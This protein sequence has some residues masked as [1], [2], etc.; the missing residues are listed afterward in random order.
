MIS[1]NNKDR[2]N[3]LQNELEDLKQ[4]NEELNSRIDEVEYINGS[5]SNNREISLQDKANKRLEMNIKSFSLDKL[6]DINS[7]SIS[8]DNMLYRVSFK[9]EYNNSVIEYIPNINGIT[10]YDSKSDTTFYFSKLDPSIKAKYLPDGIYF[11][12]NC[13]LP[14]CYKFNSKISI[15]IIENRYTLAIVDRS[16]S[17]EDVKKI[18]SNYYELITIAKEY[19]F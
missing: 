12:G 10:D 6:I 19:N 3:E 5:S 1:C 9:C 7:T 4:Q 2:E 8:I 18:L 17:P 16:T 14:G 15:P 11:L 13:T